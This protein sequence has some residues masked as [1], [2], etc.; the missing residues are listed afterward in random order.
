MLRTFVLHC[1][2]NAQMSYDKPQLSDGDK[3]Q[4]LLYRKIN[5]IIK[6]LEKYHDNTKSTNMIIENYVM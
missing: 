3:Q 4:T 1:L 5:N 2:R 6:I